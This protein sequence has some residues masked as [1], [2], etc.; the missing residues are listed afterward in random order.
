MLI[1]MALDEFLISSVAKA[2]TNWCWRRTTNFLSVS[3][4]FN[5]EH[6]ETSS[7]PLELLVFNL[8]WNFKGALL[9]WKP[10]YG[11]WSG[12][13]QT[14]R[15]EL[16]NLAQVLLTKEE[17]AVYGCG[18]GGLWDWISL[19]ETSRNRSGV[20]SDA[21]NCLWCFP[22]TRAQ[23]TTKPD[24][25]RKVRTWKQKIICKSC[26]FETT[27]PPEKWGAFLHS[28]LLPKKKNK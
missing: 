17:E 7:V 26:R 18:G 16:H 6:Q 23:Q 3:H 24:C 1:K 4:A 22:P 20:H 12:L 28:N 10:T 27:V 9:H 15:S 25:S 11:F 21:S 19:R 8:L 14:W 2:S 13:S 5:S